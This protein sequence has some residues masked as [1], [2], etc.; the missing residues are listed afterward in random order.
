MF[1]STKDGRRL[2]VRTSGASDGIPLL[3][4]HGT[5][6]AAPPLR[7]FEDAAHARGCTLITYTRAGYGD[8]TRLPGRAVVDVVS[9]MEDVLDHLGISRCLVA[10]MSGG[11]PHALATAARLPERVIGTLVMSGLMPDGQPGEDF[12]AGMGEDNVMEFGL[13]RQGETELRREL[14]RAAAE[15]RNITGEAL[16]ESMAS[17]L[18]PADRAVLS[19]GFA[20]DI[21]AYFTTGLRNG[22]DGWV[23]DS[24]AFVK[25]WGFSVA[26]IAVPTFVWQ[27][28][29]DLMVPPAHGEW[30]SRMIPGAVLHLEPH[31]G[32]L[33]LAAH[34]APLLDEL[35]SAL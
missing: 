12:T 31:E 19:P 29:Q 7:S 8:S 17:L 5:P 35:L 16:R 3:F 30:L 2:E 20:A 22:V 24:L 6:G 13:A 28:K 1:V 27:G 26:E 4:H 10:G 33:S 34:P 14:A 15:F 25:P 11:G 32:H 23:D 21:A 18:S 9:D